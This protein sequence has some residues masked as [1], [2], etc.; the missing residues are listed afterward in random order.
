MI[1]ELVNCRNGDKAVYTTTVDITLEGTYATFV[2][3]A[4]NTTYN[5]PHNFYNGIHSEADA[6][7]ILIGT[8]PKRQV[9][10]EMEIS[11][12]GDLMLAKMIN[13]GDDN[14]EPILDIN[15]VE[16]PFI[17]SAI[18]KTEKGYIATVSFDLSD[19]NTGDGEVYFN[20][21]RLETDGEFRD[22]HLFS[23]IPTMRPKF[24]VPDKFVL[25]K[26]YV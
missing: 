15:F 20:A 3:N 25:L 24:H 10:Y 26:D 1:Y 2:F 16:K 18:E 4:E 14:G 5:C 13:S 12:K 19:I 9:Y 22:K 7:E 8:D 21:Y 23:L 17:K 6:C 11:A